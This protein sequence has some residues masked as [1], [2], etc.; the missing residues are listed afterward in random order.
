MHG[1]TDFKLAV[2]N[3]VYLQYADEILLPSGKIQISAV[4][5]TRHLYRVPNFSIQS[6][7]MKEKHGIEDRVI[8]ITIIRR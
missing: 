5:R 3:Y 2:I 1:L 7:F 4:S 8:K 6:F